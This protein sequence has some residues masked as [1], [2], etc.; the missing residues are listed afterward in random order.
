[1]K[2]EFA[3][4]P[5]LRRKAYVDALGLM[6][7]KNNVL[8][9][10]G[11]VDEAKIRGWGFVPLPLLALDGYIF[12]YGRSEGCD[13]L[14]ATLV[15]LRTGKCPILFSSKAFLFDGSCPYFMEKFSEEVDKPSFSLR[16]KSLEDI[17]ASLG[18]EFSQRAYEEGKETLLAID[19]ELE[20]L[21][22][23]EITGLEL[24]YAQFYS[25]YETDLELRKKRLEHLGKGRD[26]SQVPR[27]VLKVPCPGGIAEEIFKQRK[28]RF[29]IRERKGP[30]D[31][32]CPGCIYPAG[33]YLK[34]KGE[35]NEHKS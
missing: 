27:K 24:F 3:V 18:G 30:C 9:V 8:G 23:S 33:K 21:R 25:L 34:Y 19:R 14:A 7:E 11:Q 22:N 15:Y 12:R 10:F 17:L 6:Q 2:E 35:N 13:P 28:E 31:Y 5:D 32:T 16:E 20:R 4:L 26:K 1:M 29:E